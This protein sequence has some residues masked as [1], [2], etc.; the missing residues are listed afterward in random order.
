MPQDCIVNMLGETCKKTV[1]METIRLDTI[2]QA[3]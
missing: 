3:L 1:V 2:G